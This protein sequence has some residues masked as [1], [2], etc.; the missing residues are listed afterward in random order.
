LSLALFSYAFHPAQLD[1]RQA[2][3]FGSAYASGYPARDRL[4]DM[5]LEFFVKFGSPLTE[6]QESKPRQEFRDHKA[7]QLG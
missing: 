2:T 1:Q 6:E 5:K 4:F 3:C 7:P